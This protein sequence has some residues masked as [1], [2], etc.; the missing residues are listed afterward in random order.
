MII[1]AGWLRVEAPHR[2]DYLAGCRGVIEAARRA[3]GCLDFA[4]T[5]DLV[6]SDRIYVYERWESAQTLK[7]FRGSGPDTDQAERIL[8]AQVQQ[9]QVVAAETV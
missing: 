7:Q 2:R 4:L 6:S 3:E 9:Y 8:E 1:V 5:A